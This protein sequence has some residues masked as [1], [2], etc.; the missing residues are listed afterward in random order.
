MPQGLGNGMS[1]L[2]LCCLASSP[3]QK[4]LKANVWAIPGGMR[5]VS[6]R[7][8]VGS[9]LFYSWS[10]HPW[11]QWASLGELLPWNQVGNLGEGRAKGIF[12][13]FCG[14]KAEFPLFFLFFST[15]FVSLCQLN[16][17]VGGLCQRSFSRRA[18]GSQKREQ[19]QKY[20]FRNLCICWLMHQSC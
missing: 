10:L 18:V 6:R 17:S 14:Q 20:N 7:L 9:L 4:Q 19:L 8:L 16:L 15:L 12:P 2:P 13:P 1:K 3:R 5:G 11:K